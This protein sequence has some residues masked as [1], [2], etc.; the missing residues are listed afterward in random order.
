MISSMRMNENTI[1]ARSSVMA[2]NNDDREL[3]AH[4]RLLFEA[5]ST[6]EICIKLDK[7][8]PS[9]PLS[10]FVCIRTS[11]LLGYWRQRAVKRHGNPPP[12]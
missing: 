11:P 12:R 8:L 5:S 4:S 7:I 10:A 1:A 3:V 6:H 9:S 2:V